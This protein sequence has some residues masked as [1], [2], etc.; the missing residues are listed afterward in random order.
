MTK[1]EVQARVLQDGK[2]LALSK[3]KWHNTARVFSTAASNLRL[4]FAYDSDCAFKTGRGCT[5]ATGSDC[6]FV[7]DRRCMFNTAR[8]CTWHI[9][10]KDY[11]FAPLHLS[12]SSDRDVFYDEPGR[13]SIGC[14]THT[15]AQMLRKSAVLAR[16]EKLSAE[17]LTEYRGLIE[18]ATVWGRGKG[19]NV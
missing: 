16:I 19:W 5:F 2:P 3:F 7:T 8:N 11:N 1:K 4:D 18:V 12:G 15:P 13:L 6:T 17:E 9:A 10:G 14:E